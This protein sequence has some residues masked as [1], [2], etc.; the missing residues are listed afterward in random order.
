MNL[1]H[2]YLKNNELSFSDVL[3]ELKENGLIQKM[4]SETHKKLMST[5]LQCNQCSYKPKNMPQLKEHL[6]SHSK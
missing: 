3:R 1:T 5:E 6:L 2:C 4:P